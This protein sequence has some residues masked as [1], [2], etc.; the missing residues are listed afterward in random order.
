[1]YN[2][3]M[4]TYPLPSDQLWHSLKEGS[5]FFQ[6]EGDIYKTLRRLVDELNSC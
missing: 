5:E 6:H 3:D 2:L 4:T 1:V